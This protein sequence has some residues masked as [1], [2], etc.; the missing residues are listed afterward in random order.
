MPVC[1]LECGGGLAHEFIGP[2]RIVVVDDEDYYLKLFKM[3]LLMFV[4]ILMGIQLAV[5]AIYFLD[6]TV[7]YYNILHVLLG[8]LLVSTIK[9]F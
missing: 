8:T 5:P 9:Y 7:Q 6:F 1:D 4:F 2:V 3:A